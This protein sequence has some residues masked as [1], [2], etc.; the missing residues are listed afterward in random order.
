MSFLHG[1]IPRCGAG[2]WL[3]LLPGP[4]FP[5]SPRRHGAQGSRVR[6]NSCEVREGQEG[7]GQSQERR[8]AQAEQYAHTVE[9]RQEEEGG[10]GQGAREGKPVDQETAQALDYKVDFLNAYRNMGAE[11]KATMVD[12]WESDKSCRK[13]QTWVSQSVTKTEVEAA[14]GV[15]GW[16]TRALYEFGVVGLQFRCFLFLFYCAKASS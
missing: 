15:H 4:S 5:A 7:R 2:V 16:T 10:A 6:Q 8:Q 9:Q 13:W 14:T 11:D 12:K 3:E 1:R